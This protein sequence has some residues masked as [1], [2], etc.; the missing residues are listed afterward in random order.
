M[1]S[2]FT[3]HIRT[4]FIPSDAE[5]KEIQGLL[6]KPMERLLYLE[7]EITRLEDIL[8]KLYSERD[9]LSETVEGHKALLSHARRLPDDILREIFVWCLPANHN[10]VISNLEAPLL[11][12]E[13]CRNWREISL[14]TP[15]MWSRIHIPTPSVAPHNFWQS[16]AEPSSSSSLL[17]YKVKMWLGRSGI[18]S[19]SISISASMFRTI[20][21]DSLMPLLQTLISFSSRWRDVAFYLPPAAW[22]LLTQLTAEDVPRIENIA[23]DNFF[24]P[25]TG[26][27]PLI[28]SS[29]TTAGIL[30]SSN[31]RTLVLSRIEADIARLP[32]DWSQLTNICLRSSTSWDQP[33]LST[34][35]IIYILMKCPNLLRCSLEIN[36]LDINPSLAE[37]LALQKVSLPLLERL[38]VVEGVHAAAT[39]LFESISTPS[40][41]HVSFKMYTRIDEE[42]EEISSLPTLLKNTTRLESLIL[43]TSLLTQEDVIAVLPL[44]P[45]ATRLSFVEHDSFQIPEVTFWPPPVIPNFHSGQPRRAVSDTV[46]GLLTPSSKNGGECFCPLLEIFE[47]NQCDFSEAGLL[48]M[49][50]ARMDSSYTNIARLK[51]TTVAFSQHQVIDIMPD[52]EPFVVAGLDVKILY[53]DH[54]ASSC[55]EEEFIPWDGLRSMDSSWPSS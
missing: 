37:N 44:I 38:S 31:L 10:P 45:T 16:L 28:E 1:E 22:P 54:P 3:R 52:L 40:L 26:F 42:G 35:D 32:V 29:W 6:P 53:P 49:I 36:G 9:S 12:T 43:D 15:R 41:S 19:L 27:I 47:C 55:V 51:R 23:F 7:T 17:V 2:P 13:I 4:N 20:L 11:L 33:Q 8:G 21:L 46:L 14:S 39:R 5:M 24:G 18:C 34:D 48:K 25:C 50:R 30:K